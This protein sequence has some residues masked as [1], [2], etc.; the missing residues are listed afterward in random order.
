MIADDLAK[1]SEYHKLR[2]CLNESFRDQF[3]CEMVALIDLNLRG[4]EERKFAISESARQ[5]V[6][7]S[8]HVD[9]GN[10]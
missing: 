10:N 6:L 8:E 9:L 5:W 1:V 2:K 3:S 7:N 4:D